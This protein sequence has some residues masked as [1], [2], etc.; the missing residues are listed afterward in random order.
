MP[1]KLEVK[2]CLLKAAN[3]DLR[4]ENEKKQANKKQDRPFLS[5]SHSRS[6]SLSHT[7]TN[8]PPP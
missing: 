3:E 2:I 6:L 7:H 1:F 5:L 4:K 8:T